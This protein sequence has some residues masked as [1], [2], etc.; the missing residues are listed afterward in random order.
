ML[1]ILLAIVLTACVVIQQP[2]PDAFGQAPQINTISDAIAACREI[3]ESAEIPVACGVKY[4]QGQPAML[5][6]FANV[7]EAEEWMEVLGEVVAIPYCNAANQSGREAFVVTIVRS[8][9][10]GKMLRC[11]NWEWS[12]WVDLDEG[13]DEYDEGDS[14]TLFEAVQ[15][16][17]NIQAAHDIP[18]GC[19]ATIFRGYPAMVVIFPDQAT[20]ARWIRPFTYYVGNPFCQAANRANS[21]ALMLFVVDDRKMA[22]AYSCDLDEFSD[23]F[24]IGGEAI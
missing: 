20:A 4:I 2:G 21:R 22:R 5:M 12:N 8:V 18:I 24:S 23:W 14:P 11:E 15:A 16:C 7:Q 19:K 3:Q 6:A 13:D 10:K 1:V 17:R 9:K